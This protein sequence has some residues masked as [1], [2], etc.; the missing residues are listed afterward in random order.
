MASQPTKKT[1]V[2]RVK[3]PESFREKAVRSSAPKPNKNRVK[4]VPKTV[5]QAS[6]TVTKPFKD[7]I[8]K[9]GKTKTGKLLK[10][11]LRL[12]SIILLIPYFRGSFSELKQVTWP[13]FAQSRRLTFAVLAFAI[14]FGAAIAGLDVVLSKIFKQILIK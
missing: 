1:K 8:Y 11:P 4:S 14:V 7:V 12:L 9:I 2:R 13:S 5:V 3:N 6:K 10:K